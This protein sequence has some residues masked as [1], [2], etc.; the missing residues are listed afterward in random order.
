MKRTTATALLILL[1]A[2]TGGCGTVR[3]VLAVN[4]QP[5]EN[6]PIS[7]P[8][9]GYEPGQGA[10][11]ADAMIF[12][13]RRGDS[14][15][16]V[17]VPQSQTTSDFVIPVASKQLAEQP[18][19]GDRSPASAAAEL[20]PAT[21]REPSL[22]DREIV[23]TFP[24]GMAED[25][26]RRREIEQELGLIRSDELTPEKQKSYLAAIDQIKQFYRSGRYEAAL[27]DVDGLI[28]EYPTNPKLH[29]MRGTLLDRLGQ[30]ELALKSWKQALRFEPKNES[31]RRF[32]ER[33]EQ[34]R[35]LASP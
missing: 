7:N 4:A 33:K 8:F 25:E 27:L 24:Q 29:E 15:V 9:I 2:L 5:T 23:R 35:S 18:S 32:I 1:A 12:R 3:K 30:L 34:K 16:E 17:Q 31:L 10:S 21:D 28:R 14:T 19:L 13:A 22:S 26:G 20:A 11:A 6:K